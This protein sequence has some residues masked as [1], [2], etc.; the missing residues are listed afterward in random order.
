M[1]IYRS[2]AE[3]RRSHRDAEWGL[4]GVLVSGDWYPAGPGIARPSARF[5]ESGNVSLRD[6][7]AYLAP[8]DAAA[9]LVAL[10]VAA[11]CGLAPL[12]AAMHAFARLDAQTYRLTF[13]LFADVGDVPTGS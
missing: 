6:L 8:D 10:Q 4:A 11:A 5:I 13:E 12:S 1:P 7:P 9:V 2:Q 3:L